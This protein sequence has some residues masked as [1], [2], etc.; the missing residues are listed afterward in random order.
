VAD[1]QH[2]TIPGAPFDAAMSQFGVMFFDEPE[3]AFANIRRHLVGGGRLGFA[4]WQ[5]VEQNPWFIGPA[6]AGYAPP[7]PPPAPGKSPTGPFSLSDPAR[8]I[9]ILASSGWKGVE[10]DPHEVAV[11]VDRDAIVDDAQL[12]FLGVPVG[13]F[14]E[15]H[16]SVEQHLERL[17]GSDGRIRAQLSF[18][19][20][21]AAA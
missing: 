9:D 20:V 15:A 2:D 7:P 11:S 6:L 8:A 18:Q 12:A 17:T 10:V 5:S 1:V 16:R 3:T 4:C 19:I 14:Q 13:S 21:T